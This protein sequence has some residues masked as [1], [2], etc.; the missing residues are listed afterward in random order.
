M[1]LRSFKNYL[2]V[3]S[4]LL[5]LG[6]ATGGA[7]REIPIME[8][9]ISD[10]ARQSLACAMKSSFEPCAAPYLAVKDKLGKDIPGACALP[11]HAAKEFICLPKPDFK[12]FL[13]ALQSGSTH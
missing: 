6:C 2:L 12:A 8:T 10:P 4:A 5:L 9:C 3:C 7:R 13:E 1:R 11:F